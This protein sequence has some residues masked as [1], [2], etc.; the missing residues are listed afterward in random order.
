MLK[1]LK[2][3][4]ARVISSR[5]FIAAVI[6]TAVLCFSTQVY[7]DYS[8]GKTYSVIESVFTF[9]RDFMAGRY[10]FYPPLIIKQALSGYS[11][12]AM[13]I[14]AS[15]VFV[16]TFITERNS[17]NMMYT[18]SRTSRGKYYVSKFITAVTSGGL[19]TMLGVILFGIFV[20]ILFPNVNSPELKE[21][22]FQDSVFA[23]LA[24]K[25]LSAFVYG[26]TSALPAFFL[27]SFCK[28]PYVILCFPF[29]LKF[30]TET[31]L[32]KIQTNAWSA[33][34]FNIY[35]R[36]VPFY[37]NAASQL[38]DR[39]VDETFLPIIAVNVIFAAAVFAGFAVIMENRSDRGR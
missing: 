10:E 22:A 12:M 7:V 35:E 30:I 5:E 16:M 36:I 23:A 1:T 28:N 31:L 37:P 29:M 34:N 21:W 2:C 17:G 15:F 24:K 25:L 39:A 27:C 26:M 13:P 18:V 38:V 32:A 8:S 4:F 14:T 9:S 3:D 6:V 20:Y 11:S 33:G 19:C